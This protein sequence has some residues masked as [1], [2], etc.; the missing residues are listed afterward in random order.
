MCLE[1]T[2]CAS[3]YKNT[4]TEKNSYFMDMFNNIY[5]YILIK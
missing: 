1:Y 4:E 5:R 3:T 2:M